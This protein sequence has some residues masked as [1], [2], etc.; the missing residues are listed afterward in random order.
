[1]KDVDGKVSF[2]ASNIDTWPLILPGSKCCFGVE[3]TWWLFPPLHRSA[4]CKIRS[5][6]CDDVLDFYFLTLLFYVHKDEIGFYWCW[7]W[8]IK[9]VTDKNLFLQFCWMCVHFNQ[10]TVL[11][12]FVLSPFV[13][14]KIQS[15][16]CDDVLNFYFSS[17]WWWNKFFVD[18]HFSLLFITLH[19]ILI[20][21]PLCHYF[22]C[23][24]LPSAKLKVLFVMMCWRS[25]F[26]VHNDEISFC[27]CWSWKLKTVTDKNL[28]G[29]FCSI[30]VHFNQITLSSLCV[31]SPFVICKIQSLICDDVLDFYF[32]CPWWW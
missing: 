19:Y 25:I 14:C 24:H 10:I 18:V 12:L 20:E 3:V 2:V 6:I 7:K 29:Q 11:S 21:L 27:W 9:M 22:R 13:I 17:P 4:I 1:M 28:F 15:F 8:K 31:L 5:F 16:I 30:C 26:H 23:R 32:S